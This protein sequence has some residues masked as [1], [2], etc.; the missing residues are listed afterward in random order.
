MADERTYLERREALKS[1][2]LA[3]ME[4]HNAEFHVDRLANAEDGECGCPQYDIHGEGFVLD[5]D[6]LVED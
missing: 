5:F 6:E 1:E 3:L 2:L 4:R